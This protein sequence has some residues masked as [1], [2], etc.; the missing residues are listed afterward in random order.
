[1]RNELLPLALALA[2][3]PAALGATREVRQPIPAGEGQTIELTNLA[4][5]VRLE[6]AAAGEG[7]IVALLHA[8]GEDDAETRTLLA[9]LDLKVE[10]AAGRFAA[11][12]RY[13]LALADTIRYPRKG[14]HE[15]EEGFLGAFLR[16]LS[17]TNV[18]YQGRRVTVIRS[19]SSDA[20]LLYADVVVRVPRGASVRVSHRVGGIEGE[21][22]GAVT[23]DA[24][25]ADVHLSRAGGRTEVETG[26]GDVV[27]RHVPAG[28]SVHTGSG[29]VRVEEI[30]GAVTLDTGSG[31]VWVKRVRGDAAIST[32]SGDVRVE[33]V[34]PGRFSVDTG[35]GNVT[36]AADLSSA[37]E[38]TVHTGSGDVTMRLTADAVRL[39][40][41]TGSGDVS[42]S[43]PGMRTIRREDGHVV[44]ELGTGGIPVRVSTSSGDVRLVA[45]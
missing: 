2:V 28:T 19:E 35:S 10:A 18:R 15:P 31:D 8:E 5:E 6:E 4:G 23:V 11:T 34:T 21:A 41:S 39:E 40:A 22:P 14:T 1:M 16:R 43:V 36:V 42:V 37:R 26:S 44:A 24:A 32:G 9:G 17:R 29:D 3:A 20:P 13:P 12:V 30:T 45:R 38:A 7:E 27:V 25:A 33:D